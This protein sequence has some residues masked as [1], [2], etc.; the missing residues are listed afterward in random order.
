MISLITQKTAQTTRLVDFVVIG[1]E[2]WDEVWRRNQF[3]IA[4]LAER[5][6]NTKF[7]FVEMPFDFTYSLRSRQLLS[8]QSLMRR[9]LKQW[10]QGIHFVPNLPNVYTLTPVKAVP[11]SLAIGEKLNSKIMASQIR[12][13]MQKLNITQP[14]VWTQNPFAASLLNQLNEKALIYD[15][16]DD[17]A[18]LAGTS[19]RFLERVRKGD[20]ALLKRA[21]CVLTCSKYLY[22]Q[23]KDSNSHTFL[24]PNGVEVSHYEKI[25]TKD[26]QVVPVI[27]EIKHPIVG[28]TGSLHLARLDID[29]ICQLAKS[30]PD[31]NF[32]FVGPNFLP[33]EVTTKL[34][35]FP[36]I[37]LLGAVPYLQI[38]NYMQ[39]FDALMIPHV[40][41]NFTE[42]LN[43]LKMFEYLAAGLPVIAT[44]IAGVRDYRETFKVAASTEEFIQGISEV[45]ANKVFFSKE[46]A[47]QL[48]EKADWRNRV[49]T[50]LKVLEQVEIYG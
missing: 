37:H 10:R 33:L 43:P 22:H 26:L 5:F 32:V 42:S 24:I 14:V 44:D 17:W 8:S 30:Y 49:E 48:A 11:D 20:A 3:L 45:L 36:N 29:L 47:R 7:L 23:K 6:P 31:H 4:G 35:T 13:A 41:S 15:V 34:R 40:I 1:Q 25:G 38:P 46:K 50:V 9:K 12:L 19:A 18:A 21:T 2:D 39:A 16:T 28:Y 27:A